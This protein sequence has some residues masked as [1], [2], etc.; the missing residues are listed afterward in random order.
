MPSEIQRILAEGLMICGMPHDDILAT[1]RVLQTEKQQWE[2]AHYLE[3]VIYDPP[4]R[5]EIFQKAVEIHLGRPI[6]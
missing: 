1:M 4:D 5:A 6:S 2:M 3:T